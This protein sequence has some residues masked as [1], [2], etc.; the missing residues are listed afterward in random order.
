MTSYPVRT[1]EKVIEMPEEVIDN[2]W[3]R[4]VIR[5]RKADT[6]VWVV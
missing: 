6:A 3:C 2:Y 5:P 1:Q 4:M